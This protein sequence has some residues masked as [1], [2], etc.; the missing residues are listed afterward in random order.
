MTSSETEMIYEDDSCINRL[1]S[2]SNRSHSVTAMCY[3][4]ETEHFVSYL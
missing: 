2:I 3:N 4:T 1:F